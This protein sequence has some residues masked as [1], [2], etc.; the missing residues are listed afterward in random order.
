[1]SARSLRAKVHGVTYVMT[2]LHNV[3]CMK[4]PVVTCGRETRSV[5]VRKE[6]T[7][8]KRSEDTVVRR[9]FGE[10]KEMRNLR[11]GWLHNLYPSP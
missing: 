5:S 4:L 11:N 10:L 8:V 1:V 2:W 7:K 6:H 9:I 3:S